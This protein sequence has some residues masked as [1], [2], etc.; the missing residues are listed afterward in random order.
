MTPVATKQQFTPE[1]LLALP[2]AK[3]Y[4]LAGGELVERN[5]GWESSWI[6]GRLLYFLTAF[7]EGKN[8]GRVVPGDASYQC[9]PDDPGKVRKPDVS[10]IQV[11]RLPPAT[12]LQGHCPIAPDLAA[13]VVS[14]NDLYSEVETKVG[15]YLAAGVRLTWVVN[16]PTRTVRVHRASG[17][18]TDLTIQDELDGED[19]VPGFRCRVANLFTSN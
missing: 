14:P 13:E 17:E 10:F 2:G 6:A 1:M 7:C 4:E 5:M 3:D 18:V 15:E 8:L 12:E 16:P 11:G 19:I 9:F